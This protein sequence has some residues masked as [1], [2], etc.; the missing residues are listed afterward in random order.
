MW[1]TVVLSNV[2]CNGIPCYLER[3]AQPQEHLQRHTVVKLL[4]LDCVGF[5]VPHWPTL[6]M[7]LTPT[8]A[9]R[10]LFCRGH[11]GQKSDPHLHTMQI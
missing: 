11:T 3:V 10:A 6:F 2:V 5:R 9:V 1:D 7:L 4:S 8:E